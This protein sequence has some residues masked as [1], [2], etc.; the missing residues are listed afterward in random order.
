MNADINIKL[1]SLLVL[2]IPFLLITGPFLSDFVIVLLFFSALYLLIKKKL[3]IGNNLKR[4][5]FFFL[6]FYLFAVL[7]S[8]LSID[9]F[10]SLKSSLP[11]FRY[12]GLVLIGYYLYKINK[13]FIEKLGLIVILIT[14]IFFIDSLVF[15]IFGFDFP[16][17]KMINGRFSSFLG[18]EKVLGSYIARLAPLG[19]IFIS[20]ITDLKTKKISFVVFIF[21]CIYLIFLS[22]ERT[23]LIMFFIHLLIIIIFFQKF[24]KIL[25]TSIFSVFIFLVLFVYFM[26]PGKLTQPIERIFIH[27]LGQ[28]YF[29]NQ[30]FSLF[31][32][33]HEDH[34]NTSIN[35][36]KKNFFLGGGNKS[37][38]LMCGMEDYS[39]KESVESS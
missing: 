17:G 19:L 10:I 7:S 35:I 27:S 21:I 37:F 1:N 36:F 34:Y 24:R 9:K 3:V 15:F 28:M 30:D 23:A 31:S 2:S 6:I 29:N 18:D 33:R 4:F 8:S 16:E 32:T 20:S 5:L 38:R 11:Y 14:F 12:L 13:A 22:G 39:V 25:L 26:P